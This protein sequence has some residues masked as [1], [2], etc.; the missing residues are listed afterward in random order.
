MNIPNAPKNI[1]TNFVRGYSEPAFGQ[2][3]AVARRLDWLASRGV[4]LR[5]DSV[6]GYD[7]FAMPGGLSLENIGLRR[8]AG[9]PSTPGR[10][11][12]A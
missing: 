11:Y 6:R 12:L 7:T 8:V 4:T 9:T 3:V 2:Y 10:L 1:L 5:I